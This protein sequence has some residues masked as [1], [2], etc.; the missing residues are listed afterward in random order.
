MGG[1]DLLS[2]HDYL[3][4]DDLA[5]VDFSAIPCFEHCRHNKELRPPFV[6]IDGEL[7]EK[8]CVTTLVHLVTEKI[9]RLKEDNH[10]NI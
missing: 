4:P 6:L 1:A 7:H 3:H 5:Y 10:A 2:Y 8:M 9:T